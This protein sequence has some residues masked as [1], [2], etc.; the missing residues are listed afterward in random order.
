MPH[1]SRGPCMAILAQMLR[2]AVGLST[3]AERGP[4]SQ[5][6]AGNRSGSSLTC[7]PGAAGSGDTLAGH[8]RP[9]EPSAAL[10]PPVTLVAGAEGQVVAQSLP[11]VAPRPLSGGM[12]MYLHA[13]TLLA[14]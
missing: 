2:R 12:T 8:P 6:N 13:R 11:G 4:Y 1:F 14:F 5:Q 7:L 9:F 10:A 3:A